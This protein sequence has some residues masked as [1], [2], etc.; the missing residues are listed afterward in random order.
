MPKKPPRPTLEAL[1]AAAAF[2]DYKSKA[3]H[4]TF[5]DYCYHKPTIDELPFLRE[6]LRHE[7]FVLVR[8]AAQSIGKLG[9]AA[10]ETE[11]DLL[12]AASRP[13]P[14]LTLPQAYMEALDALVSIGARPETIIDL[15]HSHF[16]HTNGYFAKSSMKALK[17]L[18]TP[19]ALSMLAQIIQFWWPELH[20]QDRNYIRR[21][22]PEYVHE[23]P[24]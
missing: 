4:E 21:H 22:Y 13:D 11:R 1:R 20:K 18:G 7:D 8:A 23:T 24:A 6:M 5:R 15:I 14:T 17:Q 10:K 2:P 9:P 3:R 12:D 19:E 16:G